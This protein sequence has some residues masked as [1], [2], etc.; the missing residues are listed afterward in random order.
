MSYE[1]MV[2]IIIDNIEEIDIIEE[3]IFENDLYMNYFESEKMFYDYI[4]MIRE[5]MF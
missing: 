1:K 3:Q 5:L 4:E 2:Q